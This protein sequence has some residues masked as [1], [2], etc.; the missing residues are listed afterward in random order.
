[1]MFDGL[2]WVEEAML[3]NRVSEGDGRA[4]EVMGDSGT[5]AALGA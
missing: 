3:V 2:A 1:M 4:G 5:F